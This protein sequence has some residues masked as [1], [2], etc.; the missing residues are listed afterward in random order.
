M[1]YIAISKDNDYIIVT[2][3]N[4]YN[5]FIHLPTTLD[6]SAFR[7]DGTSDTVENWLSNLEE[8]GMILLTTFEDYTTVKTQFPEHFV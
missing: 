8:Y 7:H 2:E 3:S 4:Y 1:N 5:W 6:F